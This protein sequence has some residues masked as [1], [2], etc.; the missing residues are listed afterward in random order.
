[1]CQLNLLSPE[2]P[3]SL[4]FTETEMKMLELLEPMKNNRESRTVGDSLIRLAK[5]GDYLGRNRD[6]PPGN[7]VLWRDIAR[8]TDLVLGFCLARNVVN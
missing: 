4:V 1:M 8:L 6:E 2:L 5:L 3:A 7:M